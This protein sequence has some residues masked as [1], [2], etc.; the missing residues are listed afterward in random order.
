[1]SHQVERYTSRCDE[2]HTVSRAALQ[3]WLRAP[4]GSVVDVTLAGGGPG[5]R[6]RRGGGGR[7]GGDQRGRR[8][9]RQRDMTRLLTALLVAAACLLTSCATGLPAPARDSAPVT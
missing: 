6:V 7:G 1:M 2:L 9:G 8:P 5:A 3:A 4:G